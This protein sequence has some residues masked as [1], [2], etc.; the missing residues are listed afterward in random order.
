MNTINPLLEQML[1]PMPVPHLT[2]SRIQ[3]EVWEARVALLEAGLLDRWGRW[4]HQEKP[5]PNKRV[6]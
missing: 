2:R 5:D 1:R 3:D 6:F 4:I